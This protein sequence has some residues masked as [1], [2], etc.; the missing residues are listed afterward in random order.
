[1]IRAAAALLACALLAGC[2]SLKLFGNERAEPADEKPVALRT[3]YHVE[4]IAPEP[5]RKLLL[6]YLDLARFQTAPETDTMTPAELTRL[7]AAAPAQAR[8]LLET[9]GYFDADVK[10]LTTTHQEDELPLLRVHVEPGPRVRIGTLTLQVTAGALRNAPR[11]DTLLAGLEEE[12]KLQP[13]EPFRQSEWTAAKTAALTRL[14]AQ[15]YA[16]ASWSRTAAQVDA[17]SQ[18]ANLELEIDS[19]PL[20]RLGAVQIEGL[21]RYDEAAVRNLSTFRSGDAYTEQLLIDFQERL[22]K[23][24]LFEG[25]TVEIE[26][27]PAGAAAAP[28]RV[29][30]KELPLQ[31]ATVGVGISANTGPRVTLEHVHRRPFGH[32]WV[33]KNK[34]ELGRDLNKW[35]GSLTSHPLDGLYR[36]LMAGEIERLEDGGEV[37]TSTRLRIGRTQDTR[38]IDRLYFA[39]LVRSTVDNDVTGR[40]TAR[41]LSGNYHWTYRDVDNVLLPTRGFTFSAESGAGYAQSSTA[42]NGPFGRLYGRITGYWP[43]GSS[44]F[45]TTRAEAGQVYARDSVAIPDTLLFRAGGDESVRG[46]DYRSLGPVVYENPDGTGAATVTSGRMLFTSSVEIARPFTPNRPEFLW[47]VFVDAGNATNHWKELDPALGYGVGVR[48]RSPVGPLRLDL[49]YGQELRK[50]R[51]HLS[52]GIAF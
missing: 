38:R 45:L 17:V 14:R 24:G 18:R 16:A 28:V 40:Q 22:Q 52:V 34:F 12:F 1:M 10:V 13:G 25:A 19:G 36:N 39:E 47:A 9:E 32:D 2:S 27:D 6:D 41:A 44:W 50:A 31:A 30:V 37:R 49:A 23:L 33:A 26:A 21:Q 8:A 42:D 15:G 51:I 48:W 7:A 5:L 20:F 46:Y 29:R 43:L 4:V 3:A 35:E 11:A